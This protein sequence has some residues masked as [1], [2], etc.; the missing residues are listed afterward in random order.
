MLG[1]SLARRPFAKKYILIASTIIIT[2][3]LT[4]LTEFLTALIIIISV[5]VILYVLLQ[6]RADKNRELFITSLPYAL[7][8]LVQS[9]RAGHSF[10]Q[11]IEF[12]KKEATGL[13]YRV[14]DAFDRGLKY[15]IPLDTILTSLQEEIGLKEWNLFIESMYISEKTGGNSIPLIE[16]SAASIRENSLLKRELAAAT[17]S[18]R[19][20]STFIIVLTLTVFVVLTLFNPSYMSV[21]FETT[22]GKILIATATI[23]MV[24]GFIII[25][26]LVNSM[27]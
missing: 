4:I 20:S 26:R 19:T 25:R 12:V 7:D 21:F 9:L 11:A 14:F 3:T 15:R 10:P 23:L 17:T 5:I 1:W 13:T 18:S 2:S 6:Y 8:S 16:Q 24:T 27:H 22:F